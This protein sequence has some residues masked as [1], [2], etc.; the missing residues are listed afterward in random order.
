MRVYL[1]RAAQAEESP[2]HRYEKLAVWATG[3]RAW[4]VDG[5]LEPGQPVRNLRADTVETIA[6]GAY[7][8]ARRGAGRCA[9]PDCCVD[10]VT[11]RWS[12]AKLAGDHHPDYCSACAQVDRRPRELHDAERAL[13]NAVIPAVLGGQSRPR[14][15][16]MRRLAA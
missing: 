8:V 11:K 7:R 3:L 4:F 15:R 9:V 12:G 16:R 13:F 5:S 14:S 6:I 1:E 2:D 10:P